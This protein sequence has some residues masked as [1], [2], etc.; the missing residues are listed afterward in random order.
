[1]IKSRFYDCLLMYSSFSYSDIAFTFI[2]VKR[3]GLNYV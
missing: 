3:Y 1:M 2:A